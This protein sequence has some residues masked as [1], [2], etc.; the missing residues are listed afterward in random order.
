MFADGAAFG[1]ELTEILKAA[2]A[3]RDRRI[4]ALESRLLQIEKHAAELRYCGAWKDGEVYKKNNFCTF[5][6]SIWVCLADHE[7]ARP[8]QSSGWQLC[9]RKGR[10]GKDARA[11]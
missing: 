11:A 10:D 3:L 4:E 9:V 8:G 7:T 2:L 5:D 6:G 1:R